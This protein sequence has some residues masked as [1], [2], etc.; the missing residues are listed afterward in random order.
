MTINPKA[1]RAAIIAEISCRTVESA[2]A[3]D[4]TP[5][6]QPRTAQGLTDVVHAL[7]PVQ[8]EH[9]LPPPPPLPPAVELSPAEVAAETRARG[10]YQRLRS[11]VFGKYLSH[12]RVHNLL[13][14]ARQQPGGATVKNV[15]LLLLKAVYRRIPGLQR[16][17]RIVLTL[18]YLPERL[19]TLEQ[20]GAQLQALVRS[21]GLQTE[22]QVNQGLYSQANAVQHN[23]QILLRRIQFL[24]LELRSLRHRHAL[25]RDG[26]TPTGRQ[27]GAVRDEANE[28]LPPD[29]YVA[30]EARFRGSREEVRS[31][32]QANLPAL[33]T[34]PALNQHPF[35]DL[36]CGRGEWLQLL[37]EQGIS[38]MG[39]D[40]NPDMVGQCRQLGLQVEEGDAL[41]YLARL[42]TASLAGLSAF[43]LVEHLTPQQLIRLIDEALRAVRPGG[44]IL[45]ETPNPENLIVG[46]C[47]FHLDPTH[48]T[49]LP[50][51][52]LA[53]LLEERGAVHVAIDRRHPGDPNILGET[54]E[55]LPLALRNLFCGPQDYAVLAYVP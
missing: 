40:S 13:L 7:E 46:A 4:A 8:L 48:R 35:L 9:C 55:Q 10:W 27:A 23:E 50:P 20:Q 3:A 6:P 28:A 19:A 44:L 51:A 11:S 5:S 47:N 24:E 17:V 34:L 52:F 42:P 21:V 53:F 33:A 12:P 25:C 41:D 30:F 31:R 29:F 1:L 2:R 18:P 39:V 22:A 45:F 43:H 26:D 54:P 14:R 15:V 49:P 38:A 16:G 36:G 32:L 37:A